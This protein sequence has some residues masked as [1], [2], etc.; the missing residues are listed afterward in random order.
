MQ[1]KANTLNIPV[2]DQ[3]GKVFMP[4]KASPAPR[5]RRSNAVTPAQVS[6]IVDNKLAAS[7]RT[8]DFTTA[9]REFISAVTN[10]FGTGEKGNI[11]LI[12]PIPDGDSSRTILMKLTGTMQF[13]GATATS[14]FIQ[15]VG[16]S[17]AAGT[18]DQ[19][20]Q[21]VYGVDALDPTATNTAVTEAFDLEYT[22]AQAQMVNANQYSRLVSV[23]LRVAP[24]HL[25]TANGMLEG[26]ES[27]V[28]ARTAAATWVANSTLVNQ[29]L[30]QTFTIDE[31]ITVRRGCHNDYTKFYL[32]NAAI[33]T[34][35]PATRNTW[36]ECP[37]IRFSGLSATT[38][39]Y[40]SWAA[41]Y[42]TIPV[43]NSPIPAHLS[44]Y[45]P[46]LDGILHLINTLPFVSKGNSFA[47]FMRGIGRGISQGVRYLSSDNFARDVDGAARRGRR[48]VNNFRRAA[49]IMGPLVS[50]ITP[51]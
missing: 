10:P 35:A 29:P 19:S 17:G 31:G 26:F 36:R 46:E 15:Y 3:R 22:A 1:I 14:G 50:T 12:R 25:E 7:T 39:L 45:E 41:V 4:Q 5:F 32:P 13:S 24:N 49:S 28:L 21:I 34:G 9:G 33:Y 8:V 30:G 16:L 40:I 38:T 23:G 37:L 6:K 27:S 18:M 48:L 44:P 2:K 42:E 43:Y 51:L 47:S 11:P 20:V